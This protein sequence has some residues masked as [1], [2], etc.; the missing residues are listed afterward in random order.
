MKKTILALSALATFAMM[1]CTTTRTEEDIYTI[2]VRD[3]TYERFVNNAPGNRDNGTIYPSSRTFNNERFMIQYDSTVE[4]Q[5]PDFIRMGAFESVGLLGSSSSNKLGRGIFGVY[6]DYQLY[7]DPSEDP[8]FSGAIYRFGVVEKRL[9]WFH[10][11][12]N[13][14]YGGS[15]LEVLSPDG[16]YENTLVS[17]I[18]PTIR[19][20]YY[21]RDEIPYI[22]FTPAL[23]I[24]IY[25]SQYANLSASLEI[26]SLGGLNLRTYA[27]FAFGQNQKGTPQIDASDKDRAVS[28]NFPYFGFGVS[29]LDFHNLV[30]ETEEEWKYHKHSSWNVGLLQIGFIN[31]GAELSAF[32]TDSADTDLILSGMTVK[33]GNASVAIPVLNNQFYAG[34]SLFNLMLMGQNDWGFSV[35]PIRVGYWQPI[36]LD[37]LS[38]EP[39]IEYNY[40]PSS[41]VNIGNRVNLAFTNE[42]NVSFIIG[43]ASGSNGLSVGGDFKREFG[44]PTEFSR[45]YLGLSF[46][47]ANRIFFPKEL[48]YNK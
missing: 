14:T 30:P 29:V 16:K 2:T 22:A 32:A 9:R 13:W 47:I 40:Y 45:F 4:R 46:G 3:T 7:G 33:L 21:L 39:F 26:G 43:Y 42:L 44:D 28:V 48:R 36:L 1:S 37:E 10:D 27:G 11:A 18:A 12:K 41:F 8:V 17:L 25:P 31:T 38:T 35:L 23:G 6:S 20:R 15:L 24:G 5:Y 19:K 34:T